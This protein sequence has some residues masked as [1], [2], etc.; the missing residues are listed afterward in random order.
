MPNYKFYLKCEAD[1]SVY[2]NGA[3]HFLADGEWH[4]V[5]PGVSRDMAI[6]YD[7]WD[8]KFRKK[9]RGDIVFLNRTQTDYTYLSQII[10]NSAEIKIRIDQN[11]GGEYTEFWAGYFSVVDCKWDA[12]RCIVSVEPTPDDLYRMI[13]GNGDREFNIVHE[14]THT[15]PAAIAY[16]TTETEIVTECTNL[17][18]EAAYKAANPLPPIDNWDFYSNCGDDPSGC[19]PGYTV[20]TFVKQSFGMKINDSYD[21]DESVSGYSYNGLSPVCSPVSGTIDLPSRGF[22]LNDVI[23]YI[24]NAI[25]SPGTIQY[26]S[27]FFNNDDYP[28]GTPYPTNNYV[29]GQANKLNHLLLFQK[30]DCK[31]TSDP[32]TK[33]L[34]SFN[35]LMDMLKDIFNVGWFIDENGDFRIEHWSYFENTAGSDIDL[36]TLDNGKWVYHKNRWE[37]NIG[38]MPNRE[39]FEFME[40]RAIDFIGY[41]IIYDSLATFNRYKDNQKDRN[42]L[43]TTDIGYVYSSPEEIDNNGWVIL[44][45]DGA[46]NVEFEEGEIIHVNLPNGHLSWS[47]LHENYWRH[48]RVIGSGRMNNVDT[49]FSSYKRNIKQVEVAYPECCSEF[50]PMAHKVTGLGDGEVRS[51]SYRLI[52]GMVTS[53]FF[54]LDVKANDFP[55][56]ETYYISTDGAFDILIN[57]TDKLIFYGG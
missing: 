49:V 56:P 32:A 33:G 25:V 24:L 14:I 55:T 26:K 41:D 11:C 57:G 16:T 7:I 30:S 5:F 27:T 8:W 10:N 44:Q 2:S 3:S 34:I 53:V 12:D 22:V 31:P 40:A 42:V 46:G 4:E 17:S 35:G 45:T 23:E 38:D 37:Y 13:E 15:S 28:D 51:A 18:P 50:D 29:T 39:H 48:G 1:S 36:R 54:Y 21:W 20:Y 19:D 47:K 9:V 43:V 52:D 6:D